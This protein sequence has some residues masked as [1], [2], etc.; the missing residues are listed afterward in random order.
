MTFTPS[1]PLFGDQWY[2]RNT[3]QSGGTAGMDIRVDGA[4]TD[5]TGDGV[6]VVVVDDGAFHQHQD[7]AG[8]YDASVDYNF[9]TN[10][11]DGMAVAGEYSHG[12][13]VAG[14]IAS[15]QDTAGIVGVAF[16]ATFTA[17]RVTDDGGDFIG[18]DEGF[19]ATGAFDISNN[20]YGNEIFS[21]DAVLLA[22]AEDTATFGRDGL[23]TVHVFAAGNERYE[24]ILSTY[25][26]LQNSPYQMNVAATDDDGRIAAF[27]TPG[28]NVFLAAPGT[29]VLGLDG[30]DSFGYDLTKGTSFSAP[31]VSGVSAL[32]LE[33]NPELGYRDVFEI[34]G[35]SAYDTG[36]APLTAEDIYQDAFGSST[37]PDDFSDEVTDAFE[38]A[39]D[40]VTSYPWTTVT[41]G[42]VD[43]NGGGLTVSHD[44]GLG[45]VDARA[46]TRLAETW[47]AD[48]HTA[49]NLTVLDSTVDSPQA[50]PDGDPAGIGQTVTVTQDIRVES[51]VVQVTLP[52]GDI[53]D[54]RIELVS[55]RGTTSYLVYNPDYDIYGILGR[56]PL[57]D[58][59]L[60]NGTFLASGDTAD[61]MTTQ[62]YGES[63][64]GDWT[65]RVA[66]TATG[67]TGTLESWTLSLYGGEQTADDR[68]VYTDQYGELSADETSRAVL[69]DT[70]GG[71]DTLNASAVS[72]D[73][74]ID[75]TAGGTID[76]AAVAIADGT[77]IENLY[78]GDG[79]DTLTGSAAANHLIGG[80]GDDRLSG[81]AGDDTIDGGR[82]LD[83]AIFSGDSGGYVLTANADGT[84]LL[85]GA[86]GSDTL[87]NV[88]VLGFDD[89]YT[90]VAVPSEL[91]DIGFDAALY[92]AMSPDLA[93]AGYTVDTAYAHYLAFG[94]DEGRAANA[95]FDSAGY[96]ADNPD[97]AAS[98]VNPL[99][100]YAE[101]GWQEGRDPSA[102][103]DTDLYLALN[104]D[105]AAAGVNP[106][107]HFLRAGIAEGRMAQAA[108]DWVG[109]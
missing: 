1:D 72:G 5:Y 85:T 94:A 11:D 64:L 22:G 8:N 51:A 20:S 15:T 41:N 44:F 52:H 39:A 35:Y 27:S 58:E 86:D 60:A 92:L 33:A 23:G 48:A 88:E 109:A 12:T 6:R 76:G 29:G 73:V 50:I 101:F 104:P 83:V 4:W 53:G 38:R 93:A 74:A 45:Q 66:D 97:V 67:T 82:A 26:G 24:T 14:F 31:I 37:I 25:G 46:A 59:L 68:Y 99:Q 49:A 87:E 42:A 91:S 105:V 69:T 28:A 17:Y 36:G 84:V 103:F 63:S 108:A 106:L 100:H 65:L 78:T 47:N 95:F 16:D 80:R 2:L 56:G 3:G 30:L 55:P 81:A 71:I 10:V 79:N 98:G 77:A 90:A 43:W 107:D 89:G 9:V 62:V 19:P 7:L 75:L 40:L 61:L 32:V 57:P 34:L 13:Q 54:L 21:Q 96:L 18:L 102:F 70:D